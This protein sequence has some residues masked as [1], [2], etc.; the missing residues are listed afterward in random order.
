MTRT[1]ISGAFRVRRGMREHLKKKPGLN[2]EE[3]KRAL[4]LAEPKIF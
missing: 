3:I 1:A 2:E 4:E